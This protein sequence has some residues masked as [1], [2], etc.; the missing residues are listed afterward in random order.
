MAAKY[1]DPN[2][3]QALR[4]DIT[5]CV[6][7]YKS[8]FQQNV[9]KEERIALKELKDLSDFLTILPADKGRATVI[10][11]KAE[12]NQKMSDLLNDNTTYEQLKKDPTTSYKN[13][14]VSMLKE[15]ERSNPELTPVKQKIYPTSDT[16][17]KYTADLKSTKRGIPL[18]QLY[19]VLEA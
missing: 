12:Y 8:S 17:P 3:A 16:T 9:T 6:E 15:W 1:L 18:D 11:D 14:F 10:L 4:A 5:R 13:K 19:L 7:K 2:K